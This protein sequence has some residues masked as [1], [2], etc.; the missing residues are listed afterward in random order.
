MPELAGELYG[1]APGARVFHVGA[2]PGP[3]IHGRPVAWT[4]LPSPGPF[5]MEVPQGSWYIHAVGGPTNADG[6]LSGTS[7]GSYGG[8]Y[9][10]G[11]PVAVG[12]AS[13]AP[14]RIHL[15]PLWLDLTHVPHHRQPALSEDQWR[16]VYS[17]MDALAADLASTLDGDLGRA[18]G[19]VRTRLSAL[20]K[21]ATGLS[22]EEYRTRLRLEVA[23]ALLFESD[24]D[25]LQVAL[26]AGY[27]TPTQLGRM[28]QRY[29]GVTP[30]EFRRVA[31][32]LR[33]GRTA[34]PPKGRENGPGALLRHALLR[35]RRR[36]A[37]IRGEVIY[38]GSERGVVIYLCTFPGPFPE[39]YP[40][41]W[42]ALPAPGPYTLRGVPPGHHYILACYCRRRMLY[43]GDF[44][45]AFAYG[46]Y[47]AIDTTGHD[48]WEPAPVTVHDGEVMEGIA[49]EM[50]DGDRAAGYA[51]P[52]I[53]NFLPDGR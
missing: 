40:T 36:G 1:D 53:H 34:S 20:F 21:R 24:C 28:F 6:F 49:L 35:L 5:H 41:A 25:L 27:G 43:P 46:G 18:A 8:I 22:M 15:S 33:P 52:W 29:L 31:R 13:L 19:M 2:F 17:V 30:G 38:R 42:V 39:T 50:V 11:T 14:L 47:G 16:A 51:R 9:G 45:T 12:P 44:F 37:T 32:A 26:E 7:A 23:K 3:R 4:A 48:P 10:Y